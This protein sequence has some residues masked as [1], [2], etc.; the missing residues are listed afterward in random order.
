MDYKSL[1]D[2]IKT[3]ADA[4]DAEQLYRD[5]I[6]VSGYDQFQKNEVR[7][8]YNASRAGRFGLVDEDDN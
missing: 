8:V 7:K 4:S 3:A 2:L 6:D 1:I 5:N